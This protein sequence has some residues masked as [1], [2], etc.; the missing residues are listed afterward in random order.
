MPTRINGYIVYCA[1]NAQYVDQNS[2]LIMYFFPC[3]CYFVV[4]Y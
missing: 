1:K 2:V 4:K 3:G